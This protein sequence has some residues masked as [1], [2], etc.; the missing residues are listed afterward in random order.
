MPGLDGAGLCVQAGPADNSK[1]IHAALPNA[2]Q[3]VDVLTG[4]EARIRESAMASLRDWFP[5]S[6]TRRVQRPRTTPSDD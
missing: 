2:Q 5:Q 6:D 1:D 3:A 4:L